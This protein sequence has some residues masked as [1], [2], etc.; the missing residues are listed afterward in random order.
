MKYLLSLSLVL[1]AFTWGQ[2]QMSESELIEAVTKASQLQAQGQNIEALKIADYIIENAPENYTYVGYVTKAQIQ[3]VTDMVAA[4]EN[5]KQAENLINT[6][7]EFSD[8]QTL[9]SIQSLIGGILVELEQYK[10]ALKY[11]QASNEAFSKNPNRSEQDSIYIIDNYLYQ[12]RGY[13]H[14][15][16]YEKLITITETASNLDNQWYVLPIKAKANHLTGDYYTLTNTPDA[17]KYYQK[18]EKYYQLL[19]ASFKG[20]KFKE[21]DGDAM[22]RLIADLYGFIFSIKMDEVTFE[23]YAK[24]KKIGNIFSF[25]DFDL[26]L[27]A[28]NKG[29]FKLDTTLESQIIFYLSQIQNKTNL[30]SMGLFQCH[31]MI[32]YKRLFNDLLDH[33]YRIYKYKQCIDVFPKSYKYSVNDN[34]RKIYYLSLGQMYDIA[35]FDFPY[36][37]EKGELENAKTE[38]KKLMQEAKSSNLQWT[39]NELGELELMSRYFEGQG[40]KQRGIFELRQKDNNKLSKR[41][42]YEKEFALYQSYVS[43]GLEKDAKISLDKSLKAL[44]AIPNKTLMDSICI[45]NVFYEFS[46]FESSAFNKIE[47]L[48]LSESYHP[49]N[50]TYTSSS[51]PIR[52]SNFYVT[53]SRA[54]AEINNQNLRKEYLDKALKLANENLKS[55]K[56]PLFMEYFSYYFYMNDVEKA[57][58]YL[59]NADKLL[60]Q[61]EK[62]KILYFNEITLNYQLLY[63]V[64]G[65]IDKALECAKSNV[66][67]YESLEIDGNENNLISAYKTLATTITVI[68]QDSTLFYLHKAEDLLDKIKTDNTLN[69]INLYASLFMAYQ[70]KGDKVNEF[71]Y[72]EKSINIYEKIGAENLSNTSFV[73]CMELMNWLYT[74]HI[75][76]ND[77]TEAKATADE[78]IELYDI[79][80]NDLTTDSNLKRE[81][82]NFLT[83]LLNGLKDYNYEYLRV[84]YEKFNYKLADKSNGLM[85]SEVWFLIAFLNHRKTINLYSSNDLLNRIK[86]VENYLNSTGL[87][88][89]QVIIERVG[90]EIFRGDIMTKERDYVKAKQCFKNGIELL[91]NRLNEPFYSTTHKLSLLKF[92]LKIQSKIAAN[93]Y[94]AEN[95][96]EA[97]KHIKN[98]TIEFI[99]QANL[100]A[101]ESEQILDDFS[102]YNPIRGYL[103]TLTNWYLATNTTPPNEFYDML[104]GHISTD[105]EQQRLNNIKLNSLLY[106]KE[107]GNT[108]SSEI[109]Y[110]LNLG[111]ND[112]SVNVAKCQAQINDNEA[113]VKIIQANFETSKKYAAVL[114]TKRGVPQLIDLGETDQLQRNYE[115]YF[116]TIGSEFGDRGAEGC[117]TDFWQ[118]IDKQLDNITKIYLIGTGIYDMVNPDFFTD[119]KGKYIID[120]YA[121]SRVES[122][123][124]LTNEPYSYPVRTNEIVLYGNPQFS[125]SKQNVKFGALDF[126]AQNRGSEQSYWIA[127]PNTEK[128][129]NAINQ[130]I[131]SNLTYDITLI[132]GA[133]STE[134]NV[135]KI[136]NPEILHIATHGFIDTT[137][138]AY[139]NGLVFTGA[140]DIS[141]L[142]V[143]NTDDGYLFAED[144][145]TLNLA[146]TKLVTL[147]ACQTGLFKQ[148]NNSLNFRTAFFD[149][150][151]ENIMVSL[152]QIDDKA[153]QE[154]MTEFYNNLSQTN[155]IRYSFEMAQ[156]YIKEKYPSPY[157]WGSFILISS[158]KDTNLN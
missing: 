142:D 112:L 19:I 48:K 81:K 119:N 150:G 41:K 86:N 113:V 158:N 104:L 128:E 137:L 4:V 87:P 103:Q 101:S 96:K 80:K 130:S 68:S 59:I 64:R 131:S 5:Y 97:I 25:D 42:L 109:D 138:T 148:D 115:K 147:S 18:A 7:N 88:D 121:V 69:R 134:S 139:N 32:L 38:G 37:L 149:A 78:I 54:Y 15:K 98:S 3:E 39:D 1:C 145:S 106:Y 156:K 21:V 146:G 53:I 57:S 2:A 140:N 60:Q 123:H 12:A 89:N 95:D 71:I 153:T 93:D 111:E 56:I 116:T 40:E 127:L 94:D 14:T 85:Q 43:Q 84:E 133:N 35:L 17:E 92:K 20:D 8:F 46:L 73:K 129:V 141:E 72:L 114:I 143:S 67:F 55:D 77:K 132:T 120:K 62:Y 23:E 47:I 125:Q 27:D 34:H 82:Y 22:N 108:S 83:Y 91:E 70:R 144:I 66:K 28:G 135:R 74:Y 58:E 118:S 75:I 45:A 99:E 24:N 65:N 79:R 63:A 44:K 90:V 51:M 136:R 154:L 49:K 52:L 11:A 31:N 10:E 157:Y 102:Y 124:A 29:T 151:A 30:D 105:R 76:Q 33:D 26:I 6:Q 122:L 155:R 126:V 117:Y 13:Y 61:N 110:F 100:I 107:K 9:G 16:Q 152:W 50:S 36:L